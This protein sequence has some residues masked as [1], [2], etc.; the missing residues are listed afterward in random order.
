MFQRAGGA[1]HPARETTGDDGIEGET[2]SRGDAGGRETEGS[3][4]RAE[5]AGEAR[6][7]SGSAPH[8]VRI[9]APRGAQHEVELPGRIPPRRRWR[10][11]IAGTLAPTSDPCPSAPSE[12]VG[13]GKHPR[14]TL[15]RQ[16]IPT[17]RARRIHQVMGPAMGP[18]IEILGQTETARAKPGGAATPWRRPVAASPRG[19]GPVRCDLLPRNLCARV[20]ARVVAIARSPR[21]DPSPVLPRACPR[22]PTPATATRARRPA[23]ADPSPSPP[24]AGLTIEDT[25]GETSARL[26]ARF[27]A[28]HGLDGVRFR[29]SASAPRRGGPRP[30]PL[31]DAPRSRAAT[32]P[33][34]RTTPR[35]GRRRGLSSVV[36][37]PT[38][39]PSR[40][41]SARA[42]T[43]TTTTPPR[44]ST[45]DALPPG[46]DPI[47]ASPRASPS[48][49]RDPCRPATRAARA[50]L[51]AFSSPARASTRWTTT[52][53]Y[54]RTA[55]AWC[56]PPAAS[57]ARASRRPNPSDRH[58]GV[59][60]PNE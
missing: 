4:V 6:K 52:R 40:T 12:V 25:S 28:A 8:D 24:H 38:S 10:C 57:F 56:G 30:R 59:V 43:T 21:S 49:A 26:R 13:S 33:D 55:V 23:D 37:S 2:V 22:V 11:R 31:R 16:L 36:S 41:T 48:A 39:T 60:S 35:R 7:G 44:T 14:R 32:T 29:P 53:R 17:T 58:S 54:T 18:A 3:D 20:V 45:L 19:R 46:A 1:A 51:V 15:L 34:G 42:T 5:T 50:V 9:Y 27:A 47:D